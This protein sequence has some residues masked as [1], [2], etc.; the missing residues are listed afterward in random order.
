MRGGWRGR[1]RRTL[2]P[3]QEE[4]A[5]LDRA[6]ESAAAHFEPAEPVDQRGEARR[7]LDASLD[8]SALQILEGVGHQ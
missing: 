2:S 6:L 5:A 8:N 7:A 4:V 3:W 1:L